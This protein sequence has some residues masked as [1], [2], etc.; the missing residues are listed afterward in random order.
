MNP[1]TYIPII[2]LFII[3]YILFRNQ[4]SVVAKQIIKKRK[5]EGNT[6]MKEL[7]KR[8]I[9]KECLIYT[10]N[11]SQLNGVVREVTDGAIFVEN[12]GTE[13]AVN[14]DFIVRIREYPKN[15]RGKKKSV[16]LD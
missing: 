15:K 3:L 16:V 4:R 7:A 12:S 6:E 2:V 5:T 9:G 10:F 1:Y 14:L 11:G 8:F 13:E